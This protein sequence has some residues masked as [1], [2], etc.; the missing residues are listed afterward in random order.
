MIPDPSGRQRVVLEEGDIRRHRW[1]VR[2]L[3]FFSAATLLLLIAAGTIVQM[4][5]PAEAGATGEV[6]TVLVLTFLLGLALV[7]C[8][9]FLVRGVYGL[10]YREEMRISLAYGI[11]NRS[12]VMLGLGLA[13]CVLLVSALVAAVFPDLVPDVETPLEQLLSTPQ[14]IVLFA[15]YGVAL[16]PAIEELTFR[17][18][19]FRA[20]E[21]II[22]ISAAVWATAVV[23]ASFHLLQL[24]PNWPAIIVILGVGYALSR[25]RERTRSVVP[26]FIV[27]TVYNAVLFILS[28]LATVAEG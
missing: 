21:D 20:L 11:G 17:G 16:A 24:W 23:F 28:A 4:L 18:F 8:T 12:L 15:I 13:L 5:T 27:H 26:G 7:G 2:D 6:V 1:R 10:S 22:G 14:A 9:Y 19:L 3:G 25:L